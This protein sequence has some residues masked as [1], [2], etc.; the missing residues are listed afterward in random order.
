MSTKTGLLLINA[1]GE[2]YF[3]RNGIRG[4]RLDEDMTFAAIDPHDPE[5]RA[6]TEVRIEDSEFKAIEDAK[7]QA[8]ELPV[9]EYPTS[10]PRPGEENLGPILFQAFNVEIVTDDMGESEVTGNDTGLDGT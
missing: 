10:R 8:L 2:M 7:R 3:I 6:I 5:V 4:S 9:R 1:G